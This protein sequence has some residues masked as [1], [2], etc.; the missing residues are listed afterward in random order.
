MSARR[1]KQR[2]LGEPIERD[3]DAERDLQ[4]EIDG[5]GEQLEGDELSTV[6]GELG[7]SSNAV[8]KV[9]RLREGRRVEFVDEYSAAGFSLKLLQEQYGGGD[10]QLTGRA[11]GRFV[12]RRTVSIA[13]PLKP[14]APPAPA[15][16]SELAQLAAMMQKGFE[17]QQQLLAMLVGGGANSADKTR[18]QVL[19][20]L[21]AMREVFGMGGAQQSAAMGPAQVVEI[22]KLGMELKGKAEG[23]E[24]GLTDVLLKAM[25]TFGEPLA[26]VIEHAQTQPAPAAVPA[27]PAPARP[28]IERQPTVTTQGKQQNPFAPYIG[29]LL[30]QAQLGTDPAGVADFIGDRLSEEQE[31]QLRQFL[32][33][34]D[35]VQKLMQFDPRVGPHAEWFRVLGE[36]L[37]DLLSDPDAADSE[38]EQ[39]GADHGNAG[40]DS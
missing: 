37:R 40:A 10:Y 20:E 1:K 21:K 22:M 26:K 11:G 18:A 30:M 9:E 2:Q 39:F 7:G 4:E 19:E 36:E 33:A 14:A 3:D 12:F 27:I 17:Q 32:A 28:P 15:P 16:S 24:A 23:G 38:G 34:G 8:V 5:D 6:L 35:P 25:E 29:Q 13:Q 31:L